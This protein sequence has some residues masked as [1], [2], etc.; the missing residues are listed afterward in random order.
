MSYGFSAPDPFK[1]YTEVLASVT[2]LPM[3]AQT[4]H[5][6][7]SM[8]LSGV[9]A[10]FSAARFYWLLEDRSLSESLSSGQRLSSI[11]GSTSSEQ[12]ADV[13]PSTPS[14]IFKGNKNKHKESKAESVPPSQPLSSAPRSGPT[15]RYID[16]GEPSSLSHGEKVDLSR[17]CYNILIQKL[18]PE[19]YGQI[20][21]L[22]NKGDV[23]GLIRI[24]K[25][26]F[27]PETAVSIYGSICNLIKAKQSAEERSDV[28]INRCYRYLDQ[29][30][31]ALK[32]DP[33]L[34]FDVLLVSSVYNGLQPN[35]Q[36]EIRKDLF[37]AGGDT[38]QPKI[39]PELIMHTLKTFEDLTLNGRDRNRDRY[40]QSGHGAGRRPGVYKNQFKGK[41]FGQNNGK[42]CSFCKFNGHTFDECRNKLRQSNN[43][44]KSNE[45]KSPTSAT[46]PPTQESKPA[47]Q[48]TQSNSRDVSMT[49]IPANSGL[50]G[51]A[52]PSAA[53]PAPSVMSTSNPDFKIHFILDS[54]S[55][56]HACSERSLF[57]E[58]RSC[59]PREFEVANGQTFRVTHCG[60]VT[61]GPFRDDTGQ[62]FN[63]HLSDVSYFPNTGTNLIS[64]TRLLNAGHQI[65]FK[66]NAAYIHINRTGHSP[67]SVVLPHTSGLFCHAQTLPNSSV[68]SAHAVQTRSQAASAASS[69]SAASSAASTSS[70][71]PQST[72]GTGPNSKSSQDEGPVTEG[73]L[74]LF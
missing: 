33:K 34:L 25:I 58:L 37:P 55:S 46:Q 54:G 13:P 41:R 16:Y 65:S 39:T 36:S 23:Y 61:L 1:R 64:L 56:T 62:P 68:D 50:T 17:F 4:E 7:F 14:T 45:H 38:I 63:I 30:R 6:V 52:S 3:K 49:V 18:E 60:T 43:G 11:S 67:A 31:N 57:T 35:Y 59:E 74:E 27:N 15:A 20:S 32:G 19:V 40:G 26:K 73:D 5:A 9:E 66:P 70:T 69:S 10:A 53:A 29:V 12:S 51:R 24:L 22:H 71:Q 28:F 48:P 72:S 2:K 8:W 21:N 44:S 42:F 47:Q